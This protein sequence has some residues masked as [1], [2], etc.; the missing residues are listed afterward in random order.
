MAF[1][2]RDSDELSTIEEASHAGSRTSTIMRKKT[3]MEKEKRM[4]PSPFTPTKPNKKLPP[5]PFTADEERRLNIANALATPSIPTPNRQNPNPKVER[6]PPPKAPISQ[7]TSSSRFS[8]PRSAARRKL[9]PG[10]SSSHLNKPIT[11]GIYNQ[12][13][14]ASSV[15]SFSSAG[16]FSL[17]S[18]NRKPMDAVQAGQLKKVAHTPLQETTNIET[19]AYKSLTRPHIINSNLRVASTDSSS[20]D[21]SWRSLQPSIDISL[22]RETT[23][24]P[25][26]LK[27]KEPLAFTDKN[28]V[29]DDEDPWVDV[30]SSDDNASIGT[31][32]LSISKK[33]PSLQPQ[34]Q[35]LALAPKPTH[36]HENTTTNHDNEGAGHAYS[37]PNSPLN[38]TNSESFQKEKRDNIDKDN[39]SSASR[40][41]FYSNGQI[42]IPDLSK[43]AVMD[44]YSFKTHSVCS[45]AVF[46]ETRTETSV[47]EFAES[48]HSQPQPQPPP[49]VSKMRFPSE[50]ALNHL[51]EQLKLQSLEDDS[52][53]E[54]TSKSASDSYPKV[55]NASPLRHRRGKSMHSINFEVDDKRPSGTISSA[56][57]ARSKS[58]DVL[59]QTNRPNRRTHT[60]G[61]SFDAL[62]EI[63][64]MKLVHNQDAPG[65]TPGKTPG[66]TPGETP[67][68]ESQ[69][70]RRSEAENTGAGM[71]KLTREKE[72]H[73][74]AE[75]MK[76]VICEPPKAVQYAVDFKETNFK[77]DDF[78][79]LYATPKIPPPPS[80]KEMSSPLRK[81]RK[82]KAPANSK[83]RSKT[84]TRTSQEEDN[85]RSES[86]S[87]TIDLTDE[88]GEKCTVKRT[89]STTSYKSVT[90]TIN[91]ADVEVII[92]DDDD[93]EAEAE[94]E[95]DDDELLS[96]YSKYRNDS[97]LFGVGNAS[98]IST[99]SSRGSANT[100]ENANQLRSLT[101]AG[102]IVHE[103]NLKRSNVTPADIKQKQRPLA[104]R[105]ATMATAMRRAEEER[106]EYAKRGTAPNSNDNYFDYAMNENY[107]FDTFMKET[108]VQKSF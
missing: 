78:G 70:Q 51:R 17:Y 57:H 93:D 91:G 106:R 59:A 14:H 99:A 39:R 23:C 44:Q 90:E 12:D 53:F 8:D 32:P 20:S 89:N 1:P 79:A 45:E 42:E 38:V 92:L 54:V 5:L 85:C 37:F 68:R 80:E 3:T 73:A 49:P 105:A 103:L 15:S 31:A 27:S 77:D 43:K 22:S 100:C 30:D 18:C 48:V 96:I 71:D 6:S 34:P 98:T 11:N 97:W 107:N 58:A 84:K 19:H 86:D 69:K 60:R 47:S 55:S 25:A 16:E 64:Q 50:G 21:G 4:E 33:T 82:S 108:R 56:G 61:N 88:Q 95:A 29:K 102:R 24:T 66:E 13:S 7:T 67:G 63:E 35:P 101:T 28:V 83:S 76:I 94:T 10:E 87:I 62:K 40:H 75:E 74:V 9:F 104:H 52:D 36:N 81:T 2:Y 26:R 72:A 65:K 41:I 46:S